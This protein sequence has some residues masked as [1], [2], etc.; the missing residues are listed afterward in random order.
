MISSAGEPCDPKH[1]D[2]DEED[3]LI[4]LFELVNSEDGR[5]ISLT[6]ISK[7]ELTP[8]QYAQ[9]L[10]AYAERIMI[11]GELEEISAGTMN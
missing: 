10:I 3:Q 9:E 5:I 1:M 6:C 8:D 4:P 2:E 7:H 11:Y